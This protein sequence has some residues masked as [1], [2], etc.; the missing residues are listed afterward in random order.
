MRIK[1]TVAIALMITLAGSAVAAERVLSE[2]FPADGIEI[3]SITN[4]VGSF[5]LTTDQIEEVRVEVKLIPRRGGIFSSMAKA[6][7]EVANA[8]L[9]VNREAP[10]LALEVEAETNEP[11]FEARWKIRVPDRLKLELEQGVGDVFIKGLAGGVDMEVGVGEVNL[12]V[13]TGDVGVSVG[14][15]DAVVRAPSAEFG[16]VDVSGGVGGAS[17]VVD[18]E[19]EKGEGFVSHSSRWRGNGPNSIELE[20]GVGDGTVILD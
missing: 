18:G 17:V 7:R 3:I 11:R 5:T 10:R 12:E 14:V 8:E 9:T 19:V 2:T 1:H 4:G 20:V 13:A 16:A 6:E 15:G